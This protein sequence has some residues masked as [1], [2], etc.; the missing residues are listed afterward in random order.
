[1]SRIYLEKVHFFAG[2]IS[3]M[4]DMI[5]D[6]TPH[7]AGNYFLN[8]AKNC[9]TWDLMNIYWPDILHDMICFVHIT[10]TQLFCI[11][12]VIFYCVK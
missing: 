3:N 7:L 6:T 1:M 5:G 2:V 10:S 8:K 4:L 11:L 9:I 12:M